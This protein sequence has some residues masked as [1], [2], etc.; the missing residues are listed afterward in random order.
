PDLPPSP[1]QPR[2]SRYQNAS[3][4]RKRYL[5]GPV[6]GGEARPPDGATLPAPVKRQAAAIRRL[7]RLAH[8][9]S[10]GAAPKEDLGANGLPHTAREQ[11][12]PCGQSGSS[13]CQ[14]G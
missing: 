14:A 11:C 4:S 5:A 6:D 12:F 7:V 10:S 1:S 3:A 8:G 13:A 9:I 2:K